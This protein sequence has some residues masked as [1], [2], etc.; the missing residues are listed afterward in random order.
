MVEQREGEEMDGRW[1]GPGL[2]EVLAHLRPVY[3]IITTA[4]RYGTLP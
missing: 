2:C 4:N 1:R 3:M